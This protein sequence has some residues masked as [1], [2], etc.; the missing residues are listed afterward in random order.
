MGYP[1]AAL[2][3]IVI[4]AKA[5]KAVTD[6]V[7]LRGSAKGS[8]SRAVDRSASRMLRG[9]ARRNELRP[10]ARVKEGNGLQVNLPPQPT[11]RKEGLQTGQAGRWMLRA[12]TLPLAEAGVI[13]TRSPWFKSS[14]AEHCSCDHH[15]RS[16][17][18]SCHVLA[19]SAHADSDRIS[20]STPC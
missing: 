3:A 8:A 10:W 9:S 12:A 19:D 7:S 15:A 17:R 11:A 14:E 5:D 1:V 4:L 6:T 2:P 20:I 13:T 18:I 16:I